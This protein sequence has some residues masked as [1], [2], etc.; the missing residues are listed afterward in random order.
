MKV[1]EI[2]SELKDI[3]KDVSEW[4]KFAEAKNIA[5]ITLLIFILTQIFDGNIS[6]N[7]FSNE[8]SYYILRLV[9][10]SSLCIG[11]ISYIPFL[12]RFK[13]VKWLV[14]KYCER[15]TKES[16]ENIV[17]Y[18]KCALKQDDNILNLLGVPDEEKN[19]VIISSYVQQI[20]QV[21]KVTATKLFIFDTI[22]CINSISAGLIFIVELVTFITS[23]SNII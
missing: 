14:K 16:K 17:F 22:V 9:M 19:N 12:N 5:S 3:Y 23:K 1:D 13:L 4:L 18:L 2:I 15:R 10:I 21:S 11:V 6:A 7:N 8:I 20:I